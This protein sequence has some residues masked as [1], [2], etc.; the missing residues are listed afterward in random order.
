MNRPEIEVAA[1][2]WADRLRGGSRQDNG[3][4]AQSLFADLVSSRVM[5]PTPEQIEAFRLALA[6]RLS[7][8]ADANPECWDADNPN[9]GSAGEGRCFGTDYS[10]DGLLADALND[11]GLDDRFDALFPMK[12]ILWLGPGC[13]RVRYGYS[14]P[15][16]CLYGR[17]HN[18]TPEE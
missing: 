3:D 10:P 7:D 1:L 11:A 17:E 8:W 18:E 14:E 6:K 16:D 5:P 13:V 15:M 2:W 4:A 12:T 9:R